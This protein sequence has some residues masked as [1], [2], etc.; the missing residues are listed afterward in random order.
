M[1]FDLDGRVAIVTGGAQGLGAAYAVGL[2]EAGASV[3]VADLADGGATVTAVEAA[4]GRAISTLTDVSN[5]DSVTEMAAAAIS[6]FGRIDVLVN[7]A[8]IYAG[9]QMK[10]FFEVSVDEWDQ[11][12]AVNV[13]GTFLATRAV[14]GHM[15]ERGSG[16]IINISSA[17]IHR[18]AAGL[19]HYVTSKSAIVGFTR[20]IARELGKAGITANVVTPGFTMSDA[21]KDLIAPVGD[22]AV[23]GVVALQAIPRSEQPEDLV[24]TVVYLA[25]SAS[26]FMTGQTINIDGGWATP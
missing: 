13:R 18:G 20:T 6:E 21:S 10:P 26:D 1:S 14:V 2:A 12:M 11:I 24:G 25:S 23:Q 17:T 15:M 5:P 7:N 3:V 22:A 16:K 19:S 4:G 9:L 8:A